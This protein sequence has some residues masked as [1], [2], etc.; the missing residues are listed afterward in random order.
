[1]YSAK[2]LERLLNKYEQSTGQ[3]LTM[4]SIEASRQMAEYLDK[5][6]D[7]QNNKLIR[8]ITPEEQE[9]IDNELLLCR[10]HFPYWVERY[11]KIKSFD[12]RVIYFNFNIAQKFLLSIICDMEDAGIP[13]ML[14]LLK[15][16]QLGCSTIIQLMITHR[17]TFYA[18]IDGLT[19]S[20]DPNKTLQLLNQVA[21]TALLESPWWICRDQDKGGDLIIRQSG[22]VFAERTSNN[23]ALNWQHGTQVSGIARGTTPHVIHLTELPDFK[24]PKDIV[25]SSLMNAVHENA[26]TL[27]VLESTASGVDDWWHTFWK[28]NK[29]LW[30]TGQARFRPIF[31]PW[32]LGTDVWPPAA[33]TQDKINRGIFQTYKP[34]TRAIAHAKTAEEYVRATP[35]LQRVLGT[36]WQMPIEQLMYWEFARTYAIENNSVKQWLQEVGAANDMECFQSGATD[37]FS[38][39]CISTHKSLLPPICQP[40]GIEAE[41]ITPTLRTWSSDQLDL[42]SATI[43]L[44][45]SGGKTEFN[46][47]FIPLSR[48][49]YP[50]N[51]NPSGKLLVWD[52][53]EQGYDYVVILD[54]AKGA[55]GDN[56]S[57]QVVRLATAWEKARQV[58]EFVANDYTYHDIWP[59]M[60]AMG[61]YYGQFYNESSDHRQPMFTIELQ[62]NGSEVQQKLM[63]RGWTRFYERYSHDGKKR[64][65]L[66][67]GWNTSP[68]TRPILI[69]ALLKA[70]KGYWF[71]IQSPWLINELENL[72]RTYTPGGL[73]RI[74]ASGGNKDDRVISIAIALYTSGSA[75]GPH[76]QDF[77][78]EREGQIKGQARIQNHPSITSIA[79][80]LQHRSLST[81]DKDNLIYF[82]SAPIIAP[83][84]DIDLPAGVPQLQT[85]QPIGENNLW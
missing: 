79:A 4:Y 78:I 16:R 56:I 2:I 60:L 23:S 7:K 18:G 27:F 55:G 28:A 26:F 45:Y 3:K 61:Q 62:S 53:P 24:N 69:D 76:S 51:F 8:P 66:G 32:Y 36:N 10:M 67:H 5:L 11:A 83:V 33:W 70:V 9:F 38:Y 81:D 25:E 74:E 54:G 57:I 80:K 82:C 85:P 12:G 13:L 59:V 6:W 65:F 29:K 77:I 63:N 34:S 15:L 31:I 52:K 75:I 72:K 22:E 35:L 50:A 30:D 19:A 1:M 46:A 39:E 47:K 41:E 20:N 48:V 58:A 44:K 14:Q 71:L 68:G 40:Y 84:S 64:S 43:A 17:F 73:P 42:S 49:G 37:I 21:G